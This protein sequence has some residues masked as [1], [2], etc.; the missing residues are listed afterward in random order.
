MTQARDLADSNFT[1]IGGLQLG[2]TGAANLLEDYEE[3]TWTPTDDSGASLTFTIN[4]T[5]RYV[6][7]GNIVFVSIYMTFPATSSTA[8]VVI[9]GLPFTSGEGYFYFAGRAQS[10]ATNNLVMQ[11]NKET[12]QFQIYKNNT[13]HESRPYHRKRMEH[14]RAHVERASSC[15]F[16]SMVTLSLLT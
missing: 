15:V 6:K 3:G 14:L 7:I 10:N 5:G 8:S 9:G 12:D 11:V 4:K 2:G 16:I 1:T 13:H